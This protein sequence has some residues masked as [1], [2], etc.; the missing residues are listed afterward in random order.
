VEANLIDVAV[1][2][3]RVVDAAGEPVMLAAIYVVSAPAPQQDI[4]Q[5]TS[6]DG[7]F[8]LGAPTPGL[9][10]IGARTDAAGEGRTS[11]TVGAGD[12]DVHAEIVLSRQA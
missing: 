1:I 11:V 10:V 2:R 4:A 6:V 5:L 3:G 8:A 12:A 7:G 9:Y